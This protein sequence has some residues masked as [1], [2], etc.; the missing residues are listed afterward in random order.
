MRPPSGPQRNDALSRNHAAAAGFVFVPKYITKRFCCK[1]KN[2]KEL[3][4]CAG[5][6]SGLPS[7]IEESGGW[8]FLIKRGLVDGALPAG[9]HHY[10]PP[11]LLQFADVLMDRLRPV[12]D[13]GH[14][15]IFF[16][17]LKIARA[18]LQTEQVRFF[19]GFEKIF[20]EIANLTFQLFYRLHSQSPPGLKSLFTIS[21]EAILRNF[22][23]SGKDKKIAP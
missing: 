2:L 11:F 6:L 13:F 20:L 5:T 4:K 22:F 9:G 23:I 17:Q 21:N 10:F 19:F 15:F 18:W 12:F 8:T 16:A 3:L 1:S 14:G 7:V